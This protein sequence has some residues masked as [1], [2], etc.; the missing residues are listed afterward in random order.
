MRGDKEQ[1]RN[2]E[3]RARRAEGHPSPPLPSSLCQRSSGTTAD[4]E[5]PL[6]QFLTPW[7]FL[8]DRSP[9]GPHCVYADEM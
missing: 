9:L 5:R 1:T 2:E 8:S 7:N 3:V 6:P 4:V